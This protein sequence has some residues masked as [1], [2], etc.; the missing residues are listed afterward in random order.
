MKIHNRKVRWGSLGYAKI[1]Y[2]HLIP[3]IQRSANSVF[4][5]IAS[6]DPAKL[7]AC[8]ARFKT[9]N[10]HPGYD[11]LL[12]DPE[13]DAVYI[14]LPN[15]QH[16]EWTLKAAERGKHVL[17]EK[18]IAM[19]AAECRDMIAAC[20]AN[21]VLLMEA[22]MYRYTD[23]TRQVQDV[24]RSGTLGDIKFISSSFR[25]LISRPN[26]V[27]LKPEL[28]GGALYDV[29]CYPIN[30]TG[31]VMDEME[32]LRTGNPNAVSPAPESI[33]VECVRE[34]GV[35]MNLS[36]ILKYPGGV[37]ASINCGFSANLR[38]FSEV[39]GTKGGLEVPL[40]FFDNAGSIVITQNYQPREIPVGQSDRYRQEVEDFADAILTGREPQ[41]KLAETL[42]N[43]ELLDRIFAAIK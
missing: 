40:P 33:S 31:M 10:R 8:H 34:D 27:R 20:K 7:E 23:R 1:A 38:L 22:F 39:I 35:D 24:L 6:R 19:N 14:P 9:P 13:V 43:M 28:G 37:L 42:R 41:F 11:E 17:C 3:A 15:S 16:R 32:R 5:A 26:P 21:G 2:E 25:Y 12:R 30:F 36:A 29:G 4:H 18:P